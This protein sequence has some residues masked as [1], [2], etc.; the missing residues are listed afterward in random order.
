M[1]LA[2]VCEILERNN[3]KL[4]MEEN[5]TKFYNDGITRKKIASRVGSEGQQSVD[6]LSSSCSAV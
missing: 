1:T 5:K 2:E 4:E 6:S 3:C